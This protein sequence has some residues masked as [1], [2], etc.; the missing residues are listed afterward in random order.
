M[1]WHFT[2]LH[3]SP[4][5]S[6]VWEPRSTDASGHRLIGGWERTVGEVI[7]QQYTEQY[8]FRFGGFTFPNIRRLTF[9]PYCITGYWLLSSSHDTAAVW[10]QP[11]CHIS[12]TCRL[13][14]ILRWIL[15]AVLSAARRTI[16]KHLGEQEVSI[17]L[18]ID[19][20]EE[21]DLGN[22]SCYVENANGRRQANIQLVK[23]GE[24]TQGGNTLYVNAWQ[25]VT[26]CMCGW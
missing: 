21:S 1:K 3:R 26:H 16:R 5:R 22:Y 14:W 2:R 18:T 9:W 7:L 24:L 13:S 19:S 11:K 4:S 20:L 8:C 10:R 23:K 25:Q 17:S 6:P 12:Q 15:L